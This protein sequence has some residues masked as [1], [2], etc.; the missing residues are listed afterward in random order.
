MTEITLE[1][2]RGWREVHA[3]AHAIGYPQDDASLSFTALLDAAE[4]SL[5]EQSRIDAAVAKER[6]RC[7]ALEEGLR[8]AAA[9]L[10]V[11]VSIY[12]KTPSFRLDALHKTKRADYRAAIKRV[13]ALVSPTPTTEEGA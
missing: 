3:E 4:R 6:E 13:Q 1:D 11:F 8:D 10:A 9:Y 7:A 2:I 5:S 12:E